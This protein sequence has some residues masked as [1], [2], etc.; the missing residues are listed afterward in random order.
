M[1]DEFENLKN[2]LFKAFYVEVKN[3]TADPESQNYDGCNFELDTHRIKYRK[4][5][6]TPKKSGQFVALWKRNSE[7]TTEPFTIKEQFDY[8]I[9]ATTGGDKSG[10]FIFPKSVLAEK[11]I[12]TT[13]QKKGK[14]GFR[15]YPI[16]DLAGNKQ[17]E[18]TK[19][20]Q[21]LYFINI[22]MDIKLT[23]DQ[24]KSIIK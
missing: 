2:L 6:V 7:G 10:Y 22:E 24:I 19:K 4:A 13:S 15:V 17:A 1:Q 18:N 20:W 16:W 3:V 14:R 5:K 8:Y 21:V 11:Q 23:T 9:I 12:L